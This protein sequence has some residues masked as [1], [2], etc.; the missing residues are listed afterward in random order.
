M[1]ARI[2]MFIIWIMLGIPLG[3]EGPIEYPS[4]RGSVQPEEVMLEET[5]VA[6]EQLADNTLYIESF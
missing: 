1:L 6:R 5:Y 2:P 3:I 4:E